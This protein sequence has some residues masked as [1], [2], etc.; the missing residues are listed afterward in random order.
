MVANATEKEGEK[1]ALMFR[2][3]YFFVFPNKKSIHSRSFLFLKNFISDALFS[4]T[5]RFLKA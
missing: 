5:V 3:L 1:N 2:F 4:L